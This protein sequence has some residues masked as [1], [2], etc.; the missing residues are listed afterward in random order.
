MRPSPRGFT[1]VETVMAMTLISVALLA[2]MQTVLSSMALVEVNRQDALVQAEIRKQFADVQ[3]M[4]FYSVFTNKTG[5]T[6]T[7]AGVAG[8]VGQILFPVNSAGNLDETLSD[9]QFQNCGFPR[10]LDMNGI[11]SNTN[12]NLKYK[13]L[14]VKIRVTWPTIQGTRKV[15]YNTILASFNN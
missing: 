14:P 6:F 2:L 9:S 12:A 1:I 15:E 13:I 5:A 11:V 3:A 8:S 10:D 7:V 4:S